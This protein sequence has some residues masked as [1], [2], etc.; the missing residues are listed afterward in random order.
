[1]KTVP[2]LKGLLTKRERRAGRRYQSKKQT[3]Q[4]P[5]LTWLIGKKTKDTGEKSWYMMRELGVCYDDLREMVILKSS[6]K[7]EL[8]V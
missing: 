8:S 3:Y 1:M 2:V 4:K 7:K 5:V 6:L